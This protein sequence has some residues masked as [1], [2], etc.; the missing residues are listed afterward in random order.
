MSSARQ[1]KSG[2]FRP[3]AEQHQTWVLGPPAPQLRSVI[4]RYVGH[5]MLGYQPGLHRALPAQHMT[6]IASIGEPINVVAQTAASQ[7]PRSYRC[8]LSG[9]QA[10]TALIAHNG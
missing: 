6:F 2:I 10:T 7:A 5:R 1:E 3:M 4:A 8:V 9:L